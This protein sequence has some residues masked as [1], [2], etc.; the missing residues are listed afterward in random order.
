MS[1]NDKVEEIKPDKPVGEPRIFG[2][3]KKASKRSTGTTC[4]QEKYVAVPVHSLP[5]GVH[6]HAEIHFSYLTE[7]QNV[8]V[9]K[10]LTNGRQLLEAYRDAYDNNMS[11]AAAYVQAY[12]M[13]KSKSIMRALKEVEKVAC[14]AL[15][16]TLRDHLWE[17]ALLRDQAKAAKQYGAAINAEVN[18]GKAAGLYVV[19]MEHSGKDGAPIGLAN[20]TTDEYKIARDKILLDC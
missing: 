19:R 13:L 14:E 15:A 8:F 3:P 5:V 20:V 11:Y 9:R 10:Y 18:R 1:T 17:L 6:P 12:R 16:L 4:V 2:K 7:N